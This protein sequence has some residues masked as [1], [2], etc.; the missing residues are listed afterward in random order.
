M[1]TRELI[2]ARAAKELGNGQVV[3]LGFGMPTLCANYVPEGVKVILQSENG[4]LNFGGTPEHGLDDCDLAN[5]GAEPITAL[6]GSSYFNI[7]DSF[8]MIRGGHVD[9]SILGAL[10][11]DQEGN[12]AN[13]LVP[14][15]IIPGMGGAMD[16]LVGANRVIVTMEHNAK[17]GSS[18]IRKLCSLPFSAKGVVD[19]IITEKAVFDVTEQ[20]LVLKEIAETTS[21]DELRKLTEAEFVV[22]E[23][24]KPLV[25]VN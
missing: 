7:A 5:S 10:E 11:V 2:A 4:M 13:W 18:K 23:D 20:G 21:V 9:V 16:L 22:A 15:K 14:G 17:D 25:E 24:I 19:R 6:P 12:I 8:C 1:H 3:N